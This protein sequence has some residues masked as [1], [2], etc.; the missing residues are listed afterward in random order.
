MAKGKDKGPD[1]FAQAESRLIVEAVLAR[2]GDA[3]RALCADRADLLAVPGMSEAA[4]DGFEVVRIAALALLRARIQDRCLLGSWGA[5]VDYCHATVAHKAREAFHV[6]FL[7]RKN[8]LIAD[9]NMGAGTVDHVPVYPREVVRR[10]VMLDAS[11]L[12]LVHN[13]PSGDPTPSDADKAMTRQIVQACG[14]V[15]VVVHDH[16][17]IGHGR[18]VSF[19]ANGWL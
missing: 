8:R 9:E 11:A 1:L 6:L 19:Q 15:G 10:A 18:E 3:G 12:L 13:H 4:A 5:V 2:F 16:L 7:D 14:A 17:V